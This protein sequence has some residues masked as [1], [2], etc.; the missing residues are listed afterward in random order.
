MFE[1]EMNE[2]MQNMFQSLD[3]IEFFHGFGTSFYDMIIYLFHTI[4]SR[5]K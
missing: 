4:K 2:F 1:E 3:V 5:I